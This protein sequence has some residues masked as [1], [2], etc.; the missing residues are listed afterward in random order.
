MVLERNVI[1]SRNTTVGGESLAYVAH[2][3]LCFCSGF[4]LPPQTLCMCVFVCVFVH[5][6][7]LHPAEGELGDTGG[8]Q[9]H[10][11]STG[12]P[13]LRLHLRR[14]Q[15]QESRHSPEHGGEEGLSSTVQN[16]MCYH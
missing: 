10:G 4:L 15:G 14:H 5:T 12:G 1:L 7:R 11:R 13:A 9:L 3:F 2:H 8:H 6:P 16:T